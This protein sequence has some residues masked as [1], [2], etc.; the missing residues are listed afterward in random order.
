MIRQLIPTWALLG[1]IS[2]FALAQDKAASPPQ[3]PAPSAAPGK[4]AEPLPAQP[5]AE[6]VLNELLRRRAENPLIEPVRS[7]AAPATGGP[8]APSVGSKPATGAPARAAHPTSPTSLRR[9][10]QFVITRRA[11]IV[12]AAADSAAWMV[13]FEADASTLQEP[14]MYL[15]PCQLLEEI[16]NVINQHGDAAVF[17][18]SG[19]ILAY[20]GANYLLPT[21]FKISPDRGNLQP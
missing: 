5:S 11:R 10:G 3:A 19:Q 9:E 8:T 18:V 12:R 13:S 1:L 20:R 2:V 21:L 16:E 6:Q 17:V 14:P 4:A 15:V 7:S